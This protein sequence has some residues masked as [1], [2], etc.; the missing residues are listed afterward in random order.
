MNTS[1]HYNCCLQ[2]PIMLSLESTP[3]FNPS[4]Y[5]QSYYFL[6]SHV[7][8]HH[9]FL[10]IYHSDDPSLLQLFASRLKPDWVTNPYWLLVGFQTS[11]TRTWQGLP[12]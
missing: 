10:S 2:C 1:A 8:D 3:R 12:P 5:T 7:S 4:A 9:Y 11:R 6:F